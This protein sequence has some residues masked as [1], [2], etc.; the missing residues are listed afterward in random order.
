[1]SSQEVPP[2]VLLRFRLSLRPT[3]HLHVTPDV[4]RRADRSLYDSY[5]VGAHHERQTGRVLRSGNGVPNEAADRSRRC[6]FDE[7]VRLEPEA[8]TVHIC[9][10]DAE[11]IIL[12]KHITATR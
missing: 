9:R 12:K 7:A 11:I 6:R 8:V 2:R 4:R 5:R 10:G 1:M 3:W